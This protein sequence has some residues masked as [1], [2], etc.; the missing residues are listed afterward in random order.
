MQK[1][2]LWARLCQD[3]RKRKYV[4]WMIAPVILYYLVFNYI[5]MFGQVIAFQ[6][7]RPARGIFNSPWV[8]L[9]NFAGFFQGPFAGR[10]IRNTIILSLYD[11]LF[12]FPL[13]V[14]LAL[15]LN[16]LKGGAFKRIAQTITYM[17]HFISLVIMCGMIVNFTSSYGVITSVLGRLGFER[18]NLL[19]KAG[20]F[21][22]I[23]TASTIWKTI[24]WGSIIYLA[25]LS[26]VDMSLYEAASIDGAG[27]FRKVYHIMIPALVPIVAVQLIMRIG[28]LM[29]QGAEKV[30]LLYSPIV[31][32]TADTI[33]SYVYRVGL[34]EQNYSLASAVGM[35]NSVINLGLLVF[36][37]WFSRRFVQ[38]SLW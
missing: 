10:V 3:Y 9:K 12:C 32:E 29:S 18:T 19:S 25:A 4:Y 34:S 30:I 2:S 31:Y 28:H 38:E 21:R 35:F 23:Y 8:G 11:I 20:Y 5:P 7:Y 26:N 13:P 1:G 24:G 14:I 15:L 22:T 16:E 33:A 6:N 17:P 27:R 36:A 37:N